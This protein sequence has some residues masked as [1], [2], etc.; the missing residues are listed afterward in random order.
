MD[1]TEEY[2]RTAEWYLSM[3]LRARSEVWRAQLAEVARQWFELA[4]EGTKVAA[5]DTAKRKRLH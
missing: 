1:R 2:R 4:A 5:P 3:A